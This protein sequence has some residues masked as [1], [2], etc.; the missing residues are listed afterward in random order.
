MMTHG[1]PIVLRGGMLKPDGY[2]P[3]YGLMIFSH[4]LLRYATPFLHLAVLSTSLV[5]AR[6]GRSYA[7]ALALHRFLAT[8]L[9]GVSANDPRIFALVALL[10]G[11]VEFL[12]TILPAR[13]ATRVDP[14]VALRS[15]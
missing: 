9:V 2:G 10:I 14:L 12:A 13:R 15:E 5:L 3:L 4:R 6:R 8:Q 11:A 7:A 1:W